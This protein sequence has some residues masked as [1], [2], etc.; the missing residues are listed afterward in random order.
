MS[1][2]FKILIIIVLI[3]GVFFRFA[4]FEQKVH[5]ADEVRKILRLSGYTSE[6]FQEEVFIGK[7]ISAEE[8]QSYQIPSK[9]TNLGDTF[10]ALV[11]NPEHPPLHNLLTR[12]WM[13]IFN[14]PLAARIFAILLSLLVFP[15]VYWLCLELFD[16]SLSGWIA[17]ALLAVSPFQINAAQN[18][19]Q[20]GL[21]AV[22]TLSS[23]ASLLKALNNHNQE[24]K[25]N[26]LLNWLL[27][28]INL[29]L[30]FY[31]HLYFIFVALSHFIYMLLIEKFKVTKNL[32]NYFLAS[33]TAILLFSPWIFIIIKNLEI[34]KNKTSYYS[35]IK[36]TF[37]QVISRLLIH[38]GNIFIDFHNTTRIEKYLDYLIFIIICYSLY[39]LCTKSHPK[40]WLFV[41]TLIVVTPLGH[42]L[43]NFISPSA[44]P[45]QSRYYLPC[46]LG[47]KLAV[48]YVIYYSL[49]VINQPKWQSL[50]G[51]FILVITLSL[52][53]I[54]GVF[55]T[56]INDWGLD[57]QKGTAN[58]KNS[59]VAPIISS[60]SKPLVISEATHSFV[61]GLSYLVPKNTQFIL[62]RNQD[63]QQWQKIFNS[64][65]NQSLF[66]QFSD[67]Y[68]YFPDQQFLDF[69]S[70]QKQFKLKET[71]KGLYK[72]IN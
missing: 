4:N 62:M 37:S 55:I 72:I 34:L 29:A 41:L 50:I 42:I 27:Y 43:P 39:F 20:Y 68:V 5:S 15:A 25:R 30:G 22:L 45:L 16:S 53:I 56:Q 24:N 52:G 32:I 71:E 49:S 48:T 70:Q 18:T 23:S 9:Q 28:S 19:T 3:L 21:W 33:I 61:L 40:I 60:A 69:L 11:G 7:M 1:K 64:V 12:F 8:I 67:I 58:G 38:I 26:N 59:Q 36:T 46:Y 44:R 10:K 66:N 13:Q 63:V 65:N 6:Q 2:L 35:L 14:F 57:N 47:I 17:M 54:S 31:T 51:K